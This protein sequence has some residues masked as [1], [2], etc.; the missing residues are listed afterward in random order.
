MATRVGRDQPIAGTAAG[1][2]EHAGRRNPSYPAHVCGRREIGRST[3]RLRDCPGAAIFRM[4]YRRIGVERRI[5]CVSV[6]R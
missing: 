4:P 6:Q 1:L 2:A 5:Y 3:K